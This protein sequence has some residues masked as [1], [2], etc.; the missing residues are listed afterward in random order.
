MPSPLRLKICAW[1]GD[2][3]VTRSLRARTCSPKCSAQL[4]EREHGPTRGVS[5][6]DYP[7]AI[8]D[9]VRLMYEQGSTI[10]EVQAAHPGIKVQNVM[11]RYGIRSRAAVKRNQRG[12]SNASWKGDAASY[13]ALHLRVEA[14]R[15]KPALCSA[16]GATEGRFEWANQTGNY[17]DP[18]DYAR[19][20][21]PC[22]RRF[23]AARRR[24]TGRRTSPRR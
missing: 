15:G 3:W 5:A 19:M 13:G 6:R 16:C 1:C 11:S 21:V 14:L 17:A 12:P 2:P 24:A 20:C 9:S 10:A 23:D 4:R 7:P 8:V 22:H 18:N